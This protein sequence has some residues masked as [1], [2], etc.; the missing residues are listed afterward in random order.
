ML[1]IT[2][3]REAIDDKGIKVLVYGDAGVGKTK[4]IGTLPGRVLVASAESG[5]LSLSSSGRDDIMVVEIS[6]IDGLREVY[7]HVKGVSP[8]GYN[9]VVLD[10]ISEIAEVCLTE[11]KIKLKDPRQAYGAVQDEV[12]AILRAFRDLPVNVYFAAKEQRT[13]D[14]ATGRVSVGISMPGTKLG[15]SVP[16]LFDEVLRL[17]VVD[18]K[19]A[20]GNI[21]RVRWLQTANDGK[22]VAKD[23]SGLL[24]AYE[25]PDLGAV[26]AKIHAGSRGI[27]R[28]VGTRTIEEDEDDEQAAG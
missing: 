27:V 5:L 20:D 25:E 26:A 17:I 22:S 13:K 6:S 23:R 24:D 3:L 18:D 1:K 28:A 12:G 4:L 9:W 21:E 7:S 16:Y 19:D 11:S 10:S 14:D 15:Q 8:G 2:T